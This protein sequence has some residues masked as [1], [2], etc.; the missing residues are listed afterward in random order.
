MSVILTDFVE[1]V[2]KNYLLRGRSVVVGICVVLNLLK[3]CI[4]IAVI[5]LQSLEVRNAHERLKKVCF[6]V[7]YYEQVNIDDC[8]IFVFPS[9]LRV[10]AAVRWTIRLVRADVSGIL[11]RAKPPR[12]PKTSP[13]MFS[14]R[15]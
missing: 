13:K 12:A 6:S 1:Y 2:F 9:H 4:G 5:V 11:R 10:H 3:I 15:C 14:K 7:C 8:T